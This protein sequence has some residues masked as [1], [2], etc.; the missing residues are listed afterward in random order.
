M[1]T[2]MRLCE[3]EMSAS[4]TGQS[5]TDTDGA[6][7]HMVS[8]EDALSRLEKRIP[9]AMMRRALLPAA[10]DLIEH[11][12]SKMRN[13]QRTKKFQSETRETMFGTILFQTWITEHQAIMGDNETT[14]TERTTCFIF[15]PTHWLM[16]LGLKYGLKAMAVNHHRTWQYS[17]RPVHAVP[18]DS[19]VFSFCMTGNV[20]AVR[21]LFK[22][23]EASVIDVDTDGW[24]P[25]HVGLQEL[26]M[27]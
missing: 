6:E 27:M 8:V 12:K 18:D 5:T 2:N 21:E 26:T 3:A 17:I 11:S 13:L 1:A 25:L 10:N 23:G 14:R 20:D 19:L 16:R 15:H 9:S 22:R 4:I 7:Q 24:T